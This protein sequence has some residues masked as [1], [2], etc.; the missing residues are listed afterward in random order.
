MFSNRGVEVTYGW[1]SKEALG[2]NTYQLLRTKFFQPTEEIKAA[3]LRE[4]QWEGE[5]WEG[6]VIHHKRDGTRLIVA[7][8]WALQRGADGVPVRILTINNDITHRK[9]GG[10]ERLSLTERLSLA[11]AVARVG[12]WEWDLASNTLTWDAMMFEIYGF[13]PI[14]PIPYEQWSTAVHHE[15]LL[16]LEASPQPPPPLFT[17][18][19]GRALAENALRC[20]GRM[21]LCRSFCE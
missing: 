21:L 11:T 12:V 1:L 15:D 10:A 16:A 5:E 2:R 17:A 8:R 3:L 4:G 13:P 7:S 6:E 9:Q 14:V 20:E 19:S 18:R